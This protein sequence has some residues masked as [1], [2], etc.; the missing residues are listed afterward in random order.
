MDIYFRLLWTRI[1]I[2]KQAWPDE[3]VPWSSASQT[4]NV[5]WTC[6]VMAFLLVRIVN[7]WT[8]IL[9]CNVQ[10]HWTPVRRVILI[11]FRQIIFSI[12]LRSITAY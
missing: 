11:N 7:L 1:R 9:L 10:L 6:S 2:K 12:D 5:E 3:S 8:L 4:R